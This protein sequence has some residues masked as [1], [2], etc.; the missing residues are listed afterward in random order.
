M[1]YRDRAAQVA[2]G[3]L[4]LGVAEAP[5]GSNWG[6]VVAT[7]LRHVG[8]GPNPWCAAFIVKLFAEAGLVILR[9]GLVSALWNWGMARH[10]TFRSGS[11]PP[12][13]GDLICFEWDG[14]LGRGDILDHIGIVTR[15]YIRYDGSRVVETVEG[16]SGNRVSRK[17]YLERDRRIYG[18]IRI[19]GSVPRVADPPPLSPPRAATKPFPLPVL[20]RLARGR[21][22][23]RL[24]RG[25]T[26]IGR[27]SIS[28]MRA[29]YKEK[30]SYWKRRNQTR[31]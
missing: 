27:G 18:Y 24:G 12:S 29:L 20:V 17:T 26:V 6:A 16:N 14:S 4:R 19:P 25:G 13:R 2:E 10:W 3:Y 8:L 22:L 11:L 1:L 23:V 30:L 21:A 9:T 31:R 28:K 7:F 15:T 5:L